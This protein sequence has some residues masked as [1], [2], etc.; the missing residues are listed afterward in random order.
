MLAFPRFYTCQLQNLTG[1]F[2]SFTFMKRGFF[3][4]ILLGISVLLAG[5][6]LS[7]RRVLTIPVKSDSVL[8]DSLS[9][10]PDTFEI[11][12]LDNKPIQDS[13]YVLKFAES[14]FFPAPS[15][16][17]SSDSVQIRFKVFPINLS[18][19][20]QHKK[21]GINLIDPLNKTRLFSLKESYDPFN[22]GGS[23]LN[24]SGNLSRGI[25]IGNNQDASLNSNLNLQLSGKIN[26]QFEIEAQLSD[27]NIP[28]QPEGN[29]QQIQD[30]D[31]FFIRIFSPKTQILAGDFVLDSPDGY[32]MQMNKNLQGVQFK[33]LYTLQ[34]RKPVS[35][36]TRTTAAVVKG[37]SYRMPLAGIEGNQGPYRL[38]GKDG[39]QY[40]QVI[41]GSE[42]VYLDGQVLR[43]GE[44]EDYVINYNTAELSFTPKNLITKDK[45]I[46]VQ[47][48]YTER[49]YARFL[50]STD[51]EWKGK[52]GRIYFNIYS[53]SDAK[54]QSLLQDLNADHKNLLAS[55]GDDLDLARVNNY[56][57]TSFMNDRV[58]YKKTDTL[59]NGI[60]YFDILVYSTHPDSAKYQAGFSFVGENRGNYLPVQTR[61]NG[62][63]YQWNEPV[64]GTRQGSYEPITKLIT[65]QSKQ[66]YS[67]GTQQNLGEKMH[68]GGEVSF[69]S[70]DQNSF[71]K[72]DSK[73]DYGMGINLQLDRKDVLKVDTTLSLSSFISYRR[74]G[75]QFDPLENYRSIE[76]ERDWNLND[77]IL[78]ETENLV[79]AGFLLNGKDSLN[80]TYNFEYL[81]YT[82]NYAATRHN[83]TGLLNKNGY[84]LNWS[85]SLL[86][87]SDSFRDT[88]FVRHD[89]Q[90]SKEWKHV[91]L[92]LKEKREGNQWSQNQ[93]NQYLPGSFS[94][95]EWHLE[96]RNPKS[97]GIPWFLKVLT[98]SDYLPDS[99]GLVLD[100]L[101][102]ESST[103]LNLRGKSG[104][105]T[106]LS[107]NWRNLKN[108][109]TDLTGSSQNQSMTL[110]LEEGFQ[111]AKGAL[112]SRSFYEI[113]SGL[114]RKQDFFYLEVA[115]GQ[116]YYTWTDY[117]GNTIKE[118]DE[119]EP[120]VFSDQA[121]Y[122]RVFRPGNEYV[123]VYTNRF[124]QSLSLN[125]GRFVSA[126]KEKGKFLNRFNN[127][128]SLSANRRTS[129]TDLIR[130]MNP[131]LS[132]DSSLVSLQSQMRNLLSFNTKNQNIGF[133]YIFQK[134][135]NQNLMSYGTDYRANQSHIFVSRFRPWNPLWINN[136]AERGSTEYESGFFQTRNYQLA[137]W[138]ND[139]S[140]IIESGDQTRFNLNWKWSAEENLGGTE[141]LS[142][143]RFELGGDYQMPGKG[144]IHLDFQYIYLEFLG[145]SNSPVGYAMLKGFRPG[146]NGMANVSIRRKLNEVIQMDLFYSA[147]ISQGSD[148]IHTGNI[149]VRAIF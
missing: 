12:D 146:H 64:N 74:S 81:K 63:V 110:R 114:E 73:D 75:K 91:A 80:A 23:F 15:L 48:E 65:P 133:D 92:H 136:K 55:I 142:E 134:T 105:T 27:S 131:F 123:P 102:W 8:L 20:A 54:N 85:G 21:A 49:S 130:N 59:I 115:P 67:L 126:N 77:G 25:Q 149:S 46:L 58:L 82:Q 101:A 127:Q 139:L 98:R 143:N 88:R 32:F 79:K 53:E 118:L 111:L 106:R 4:L 135:A 71:S 9:I 86:N 11:Y 30:F 40:I 100:N 3:C 116:G 103:G 7:N 47:F 33:S 84:S 112:I 42:T 16:K 104:Q 22:K 1:L 124:T 113:G 10:I 95:Q 14:W 50:I 99:S 83:T 128:F 119:F 138:R 147:R 61:A 38:Y 90:L 97:A 96:L 87:S 108:K 137:F 122:I 29:T 89:I 148:I 26:R 44:N 31:R 129:R 60:S 109:R 6:D 17:L 13:L 68:F 125:P 141:N 69:S 51:N 76:F 2:F 93:D 56:Y 18:K 19:A 28:I 107:L 66:I 132:E 35:I 72:L 39:E 43:R 140:I 70:N 145:E 36:E 45:R 94:F 52:N 37:K 78:S 34:N 62:Q 117:N 57:E 5:Q 121:Q 41:A 24:T 144:L 120:A